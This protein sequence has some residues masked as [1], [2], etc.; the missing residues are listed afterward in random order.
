MNRPF[1]FIYNDG[2][3]DMDD[4]YYNDDSYEHND[5]CFYMNYYCGS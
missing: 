5:D 2:N 3:Y 4:N 1:L